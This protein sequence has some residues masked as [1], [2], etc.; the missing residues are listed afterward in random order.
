MGRKETSLSYGCSGTT[1]GPPDVLAV[2]RKRAHRDS[3][4]NA[5][6]PATEG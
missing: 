6:A 2:Q 4:Q 3:T 1:V 5:Y